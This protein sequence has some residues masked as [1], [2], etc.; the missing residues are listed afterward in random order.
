MRQPLQDLDANVTTNKYLK[1]CIDCRA[2]QN[3]CQAARKAKKQKMEEDQC[4]YPSQA[5]LNANS[6][7]REWR[8]RAEYRATRAS[9]LAMTSFKQTTPSPHIRAFRSVLTKAKRTVEG[10]ITLRLGLDPA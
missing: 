8:F 10:L 6:E 4:T 3:A 9:S 2:K 7:M 5:P 1:W